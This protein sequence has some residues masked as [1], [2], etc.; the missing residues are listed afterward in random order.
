MAKFAE[1]AWITVIVIPGTLWLL[2]MVRRYY[3][4]LDRLLLGN[5]AER[6]DLR[7]HGPPLVVIPVGRWDS[8]SRNGVEY[9]LR[10]SP[11]VTALHCTDLEGPDGEEHETHLR[12]Q[13]RRCV[14]EPAHE[15]G[16][17]VPRL[18]VETSP[19]RSVPGPLLRTIA[20]LQRS[21]PGRAV[22]VV[23]P[24]LVVGRWW[25]RLL[26]TGREFRLRRMVLR[27]GG[28]GVAVVG[29]PWQ[30]AGAGMD[31]VAGEDLDGS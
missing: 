26:H 15:A 20:E 16:L 9:A 5:E 3:D 31:E 14:G 1:G 12:E 30:L 24:Q 17:P 27:H 21:Q 22:A 11:D 28:P 29:V 10:L 23:V 2:R 6:M 8:I 13:W 25:E 4:D 7:A 19:Y 18:L